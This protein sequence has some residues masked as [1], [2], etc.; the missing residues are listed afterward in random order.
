MCTKENSNEERRK[1]K[2]K[3][4]HTRKQST[5]T[6]PT[7]LALALPDDSKCTSASMVPHL[8]S[9]ATSISYMRA[10]SLHVTSAHSVD[11]ASSGLANG[12]L[13]LRGGSSGRLKGGH[14][15]SVY[16]CT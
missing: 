16:V 6:K 1:D 10:L 5:N 7:F 9:P 13:F 8:T 11:S 14:M 12:T 4:Q 2:Q 15:V 3:S